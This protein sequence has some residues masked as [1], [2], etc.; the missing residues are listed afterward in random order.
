MAE[1]IKNV[2]ALNGLYVHGVLLSAEP[3]KSGK[4]DTMSWGASVKLNF[5]S[6]FQ[7]TTEIKGVFVPATATRLITISIASSDDS[8]PLEIEKYSKQIGQ[9]LSL[10]LEPQKNSSFKLV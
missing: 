4:N 9:H 6:T 7:K 2:N 3:T 8:L 10:S 1:E 5:L